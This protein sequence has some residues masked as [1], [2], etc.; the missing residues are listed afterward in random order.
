MIDYLKNNVV[1]VLVVLAIIALIAI[2]FVKNNDKD[3]QVVRIGYLS[4]LTGA[5]HFIAIE[6]DLYNKAGVSIEV[7]QFQSSNQLYESIV[8]GDVDITPE[9]SVL[10][11]LINEL[12]DPGKIEIF[13]TTKFTTEK[14]FDRVVVKSGSQITNIAGLVGKKVG[15]FPGSTATTFLKEYLESRGVD[16]LAIE[17][18][19]L[20]PQ[21]QIPALEAGS[22]DALYAYEPNLSTAVVKNGSRA[23]TPSVFAS[24]IE[25]NPLGSGIVS[26]KFVENNPDLASKVIG[27]FDEAFN[28]LV[29]NDTESRQLM[30]REMGIDTNVAERMNFSYHT[31]SVGLDMETFRR[32][33]NILVE[34]G[35]LSS[36]PDL[37]NLFYS[38]K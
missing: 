10:P 23:I 3:S 37:S 4:I 7:A 32:F 27:V 24:L 29:T 16:T 9:I 13:T 2:F 31:T 8:K 38:N 15:V 25:N 34:L 35:E 22:I 1:S 12:K 33:T 30:V 14:P 17:F 6:Q 21:N 20:A 18:V 19:Q 5:P 26:K 28:Y 36:E 11:V